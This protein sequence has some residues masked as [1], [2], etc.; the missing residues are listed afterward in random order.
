MCLKIFF[1]FLFEK[2]GYLYCFVI[3]S[4]ECEDKWPQKKCK[5]CNEK[6]CKKDTKSKNLYQHLLVRV[7]TAEVTA[8]NITMLFF[9]IANEFF[10]FVNSSSSSSPEELSQASARPFLEDWSP[11]EP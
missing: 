10:L 4:Q 2:M 3:F 11:Q 8:P 1:Y 9:G 5:K 7:S 6:K